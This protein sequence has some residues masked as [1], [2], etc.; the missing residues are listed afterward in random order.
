MNLNYNASSQLT[1][2]KITK[3]SGSSKKEAW[4][5]VKELEAREELPREQSS[6]QVL[7]SV[8]GEWQNDREWGK[9]YI[10]L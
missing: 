8:V 5:K 2:L 9:G 4:A 1:K 7:G 3:L 6:Q 10:V